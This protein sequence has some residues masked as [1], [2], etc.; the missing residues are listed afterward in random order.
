LSY[1][2]SAVPGTWERF[3]KY[4]ARL[5]HGYTAS[6]SFGGKVEATPAAGN[7]SAAGFS[8]THISNSFGNV[9]TLWDS[10]I[11][12][13]LLCVGDRIDLTPLQHCTRNDVGF[14]G[15]GL[16]GGAATK[17]TTPAGTLI[18]LKPRTVPMIPDETPYQDPVGEFPIVGCPLTDDLDGKHSIVI[19]PSRPFYNWWTYANIVLADWSY[20]EHVADGATITSDA[21]LIAEI[22]PDL[23]QNDPISPTVFNRQ[24]IN[25]WQE[26]ERIWTPSLRPSKGRR[27]LESLIDFVYEGF[28]RVLDMQQ[29]HAPSSLMVQYFNYPEVRSARIDQAIKLVLKLQDAG[30]VQR[31][32]DAMPGAH[33][34]ERSPGQRKSDA[35]RGS[36]ISGRSGGY[37]RR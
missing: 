16:Q 2:D 33:Y 30:L 19:G 25:L 34:D 29:A 11:K 27:I 1:E 10:G 12:D 23:I 22:F 8:P 18:P 32:S 36:F 9:W 21:Q 37:K 31:G 15:L 3:V 35:K 4:N 17:G 26:L 14:V 6:T 13:A 20:L 24:N 7:I 5:G 28:K